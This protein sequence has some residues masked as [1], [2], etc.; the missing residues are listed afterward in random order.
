MGKW[1]LNIIIKVA[2]IKED[3]IKA[4]NMVMVKW[5]IVMGEYIK[6]IGTKDYKMEKEYSSIN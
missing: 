3:I 6:E 1:Y 2:S 5:C 4:K